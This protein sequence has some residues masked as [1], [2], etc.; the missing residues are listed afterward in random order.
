MNHMTMSDS[1]VLE[2]INLLAAIG[3][4]VVAIHFCIMSIEVLLYGLGP[5]TQF[6]KLFGYGVGLIVISLTVVIS[7]KYRLIK[8]LPLSTL[9]AGRRVPLRDDGYMET[10]LTHATTISWL[11]T[12]SSLALFIFISKFKVLPG[13]F[14]LYAL[15]SLTLAGFG[16]SY[17]VIYLRSGKMSSEGNINE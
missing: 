15:L 3:F 5:Y 7:L 16:I 1:E 11:L 17:L 13:T 10:A 4:T 12:M 14:Y 8:H 6:S 2:Q 9:F